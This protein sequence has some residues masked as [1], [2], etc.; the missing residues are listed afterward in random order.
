MSRVRIQEQGQRIPDSRDAIIAC[1]GPGN[2]KRR[3]AHHPAWADWSDVGWL[4]DAPPSRGSQT[5]ALY[6]L[7][8]ETRE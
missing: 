2:R 1:D 3:C 8:V 4:T 5:D 7:R 6:D